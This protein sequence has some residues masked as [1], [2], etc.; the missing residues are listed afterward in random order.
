VLY[1]VSSSSGTKGLLVDAYGVYAES[2]ST[3]MIKKLQI[4][5]S[6]YQG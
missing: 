4:D 3:D 5:R 2:I 1:A 6:T